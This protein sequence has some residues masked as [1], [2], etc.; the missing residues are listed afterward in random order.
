MDKLIQQALDNYFSD[1]KE[2]HLLI[3]IGFTIV[4]ALLQIIQSIIVTRK[5]EKFK[6][7]LKKSEIKFSRFSELQITALRKIYHQLASFQLANN[8]IFKTEPQTIDHT[9]FKTRINEWIK[10]YIEC[11][12]EFA[13]E[14]IL[15]TPEIKL[16]FS[17]TINDFE[18][19]KK[20]L[21]DER[22]NLDYWEMENQGDWNAMYDFHENELDV[23]T[24]KINSIKDNDSIKN[25]EKH[26][27]ELREK[28][29]DIF[30]KM[31]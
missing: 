28:I 12:S 15:L 8:L 7:D 9:K 16:L 3:L 23:I 5:I 19:I 11:S 2:Y 21:I 6:A 22:N 14:K 29:E 26:I 17:K 1:F 27:R 24:K 13:R 4:I 30:Q 25:S 10:I 20:I 18:E 31:N